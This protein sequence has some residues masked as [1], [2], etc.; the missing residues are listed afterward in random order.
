[1]EH[2]RNSLWFTSC[3]FAIIALVAITSEKGDIT[4]QIKEVKW[5]VSAISVNIG[6]SGLAVLAIVALKNKFVGTIMEGGLVSFSSAL[7]FCMG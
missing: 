4:D 1:M 3:A 2:N 5:A 6:L 7:T